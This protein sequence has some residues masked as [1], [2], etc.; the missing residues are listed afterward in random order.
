MVVRGYVAPT[1]TATDG[2]TGPKPED[3]WDDNDL[4]R[5]KLNNQGLNSIQNTVTKEEFRKISNCT[6]SKEAWNI[7][8]AVHEGM[9]TVKNSKIL[10]LTTDFE[11]IKISDSES[12]SD[13]HDKL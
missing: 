5:Y 8:Q 6:T 13:F 10:R 2:T 9:N 1:V 11:N 12:F 3:T 7:L 4:N